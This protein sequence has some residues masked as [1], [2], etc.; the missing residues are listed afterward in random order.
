MRG[1]EKFKKFNFRGNILVF[2]WYILWHLFYGLDF[3]DNTLQLQLRKRYQ[4]LQVFEDISSL[5]SFKSWYKNMYNSN[6]IMTGVHHMVER[7][8]SR[9]ANTAR[10]LTFVWLFLDTNHYRDKRQDF[11]SA[12]NLTKHSE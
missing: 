1:A 5:A 4:Q 8:K 2:T 3:K 7:V 12:F 11:V 9:A 6:R 10:Y